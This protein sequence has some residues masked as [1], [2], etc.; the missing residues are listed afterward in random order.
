[1]YHPLPI[2]A[3]LPACYNQCCIFPSHNIIIKL[4]IKNPRSSADTKL[5][6]LGQNKPMKKLG[7]R[8]WKDRKGKNYREKASKNK[9]FRTQRFKRK[10]A[11][12][13]S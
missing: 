5:Y 12:S 13:G 9:L 6:N 11:N 1:M 2:K 4:C 7:G 3:Y 8:L 10:N